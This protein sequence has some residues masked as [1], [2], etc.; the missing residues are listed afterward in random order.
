MP[1]CR[2]AWPVNVTHPGARRIGVVGCSIA[3][4]THT[5]LE[6]PMDPKRA[7][8]LSTIHAATYRKRSGSPLRA[9]RRAAS[10][11]RSAP[12]PTTEE[13]PAPCRRS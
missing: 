12:P 9:F 1:H 4:A 2:E 8:A 13:S 11:E 10:S 7:F 6:R 3:S 5:N